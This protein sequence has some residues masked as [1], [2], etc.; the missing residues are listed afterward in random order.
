[1]SRQI[2][3]EAAQAVALSRPARIVEQAAGRGVMR[4]EALAAME[5]TRPQRGSDLSLRVGK[6]AKAR[7]LRSM[8]CDHPR[9]AHRI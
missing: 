5:A 6:V 4:A 9:V 3:L 1:M 8:S 7:V 2:S